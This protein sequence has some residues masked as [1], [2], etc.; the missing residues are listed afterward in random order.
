[1]AKV[2]NSKQFGF[3]DRIVNAAEDFLAAQNVLSDAAKESDQLGYFDPTNDYFLS[4]SV[5]TDNNLQHL[6][7]ASFA[8]DF[9]TVRKLI[10]QDPDGLI[11][12]LRR[13]ARGYK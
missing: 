6:D 9:T 2:L 8:S 11:P 7:S 13:I 10:D 4:D 12:A 3:V 5:F 1:M